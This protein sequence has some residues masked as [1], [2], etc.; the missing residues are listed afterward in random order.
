M[1]PLCL[2]QDHPRT[3]LRGHGPRWTLTWLSVDTALLRSYPTA[4]WTQAQL[5]A[6]FGAQVDASPMQPLSPG[7]Q[8]VGAWWQLPSTQEPWRIF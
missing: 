1:T 4:T 2:G 6:P 5:Q 7:R 8:Q 3:L